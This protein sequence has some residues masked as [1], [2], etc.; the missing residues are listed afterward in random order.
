MSHAIDQ[1]LLAASERG[2]RWILAQQRADGSFCDPRDGIGGYYKVPYALSLTGHHREAL[3]LANWIAKHHL[4]PEGDFRAPERKAIEPLH[5]AWPVYA[6]AWLIQGLH[7]VG[8]WDLSLAGAKFLLGYQAPIGGFYALEGETRFL[9]P[10]CT[11]WGGLA[12]L[13]TGHLDAARRAGD[14][15]VRMVETQPD[16]GRFYFRMDAEGA[17]ITDVPAGAELF[18][19]VDAGRRQ[20]IYYN[21]GIALILLAHLYQATGE[22]RYLN[23]GGELFAFTER[24]ADDVYGYPPSGKLGLGCALLFATTCKSE[25]LRAALQVGVYLMETQ[26]AEGFW[27]LPDTG[28]YATLKDRDGMEIRL[29]IAAEFSTFLAEIAARVTS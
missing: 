8:R 19:Y 4:T 14:L 28:P 12:M 18:Y 6:N 13:T 1:Q 26:T 11:S 10:V 7:R 3:R 22:K 9:E 5:D 17:L 15:L 20:Q 29:D 25:A 2:I 21:P 24:C 27:R 16:A 23:A